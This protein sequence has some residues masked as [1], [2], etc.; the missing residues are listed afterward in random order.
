[1]S[2]DEPLF[3]STKGTS[4]VDM[5]LTVRLGGLVRVMLRQNLSIVQMH[6]EIASDSFNEAGWGTAIEKKQIGFDINLLGF[7]ICSIGDGYIHVPEAKRRGMIHDIDE[8]LHPESEDGS[9]HRDKVEALVGRTSHLAMV[10]SEGNAY[11]KSCFAMVN[12]RRRGVRKSALKDGSCFYSKCLIKPRRLHVNGDTKLQRAFRECL[13]WWRAAFV[14]GVSIPLAY[15]RHFPL[16][17]EPGCA[18]IFSDAAR[19]NNTGYGGFS[20][21]SFMQLDGSIKPVMFFMTELWD[22]LVLSGLQQ[23]TMS[24]A[25][26]EAFGVIALMDALCEALSRLTHLVIFSDS[27]ATVQLINSGN[28]PSPQMDFILQWFTRR[29]PS[30]F[31]MAIHIPGVSN[32]TSDAL[33]RSKGTQLLDEASSS[34]CHLRRLRPAHECCRMA[35]DVLTQGQRGVVLL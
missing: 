8:M 26:G 12:A 14:S 31:M 25:A 30:L 17:G 4:R 28:S 15:K 35:H 10:A 23:N 19:E 1:M 6:V 24:M 22:H 9:V 29:R 18:C 20:F 16:P 11:L 27:T 33:S 3:G 32:R 5:L 7:S 2:Q 13:L 34:G 21:V